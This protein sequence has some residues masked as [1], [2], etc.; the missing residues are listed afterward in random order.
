MSTVGYGDMSPTNELEILFAIILMLFA[1]G[2]FAFV[3][4][5]IGSIIEAI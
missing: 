3:L 2:I 1:C 4:N 5:K